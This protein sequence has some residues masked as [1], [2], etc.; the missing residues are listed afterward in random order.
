M[1]TRTSSVLGLLI[2]AQLAAAPAVMAEEEAGPTSALDIS[3]FSLSTWFTNN[4]MFRGIS[5][6]DGP[7]GQGS[8]DWTYNGFYLGVWGS[9]TE[10][11][12]ND[13][14]IDWYGGYRGEFAG[15]GYDVAAL[16]Y[17]YPGEDD[18]STD[19]DD[20]QFDPVGGQEADYVELQLI[21]SKS[22][23]MAWSPTIAGKYN[24]SPDTFGEDGDAHAIQGDVGITVPMGFLGDIGIS[25]TVGYQTVDG[26]KSSG[27]DLCLPYTNGELNDAVCGAG[28][29]PV[30][31]GYDYVYWRIGVSKEIAGFKFDGSYHVTDM[32][33][34]LKTFYPRTGEPSDFRDLIE[35][36]VVLT[37]SRSFSFP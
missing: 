20:K 30:L 9:N 35:P 24:Y 22:F 19:T 29:G 18:S 11:S 4:Y 26:D 10:F 7:S 23:D 36:H 37:V 14:E 13:I 5:N 8:L 6:S 2:A 27:K 1:N 15:F 12:D 21:L 16:Y 3:N 33:E 32:S 17:W 28:F 31:D 25:G 34:D